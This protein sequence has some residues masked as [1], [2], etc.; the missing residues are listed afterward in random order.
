MTTLADTPLGSY[1]RDEAL[2]THRENHSSDIQR[3]RMSLLAAAQMGNLAFLTADD[4]SVIADQLG[5][6]GDRRWLGAVF[7]NWDR[8][9]VTDRTIVST[10]SRRH[11]R[12]IAV[13]QVL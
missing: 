10:L 4:A 7:R 6:P 9:R 11:A 2:A 5:I 13:W 1:L 12:R 8:V 3:V